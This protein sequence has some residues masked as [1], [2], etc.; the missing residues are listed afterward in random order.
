MT[1]RYSAYLLSDEWKQRRIG[2]LIRAG[3]KCEACSSK[4]RLQAHHLTYARIF[5][6]PLSDLMALCVPCHEQ[7]EQFV[8]AGTISRNGDSDSLRDKSRILLRGGASSETVRAKPIKQKSRGGKARNSQRPQK[9]KVH[10]ERRLKRLL[11]KQS[12]E[13]DQK[14]RA[15]RQKHIDKMIAEIRRPDV[16]SIAPK[17]S[18]SPRKTGRRLPPMTNEWR[19]PSVHY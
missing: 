11:K 9:P 7:I 3:K 14:S 1:P 19:K 6:E 15:N 2:C 5:S 17:A 18:S 13:T 4:K 10:A 16:Y 8:K 12:V